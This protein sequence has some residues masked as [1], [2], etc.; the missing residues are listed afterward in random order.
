VENPC[1]QGLSDVEAQPLTIGQAAAR[2]GVSARYVRRLL[3][4]PELAAMV[5]H[6]TRQTR[7]GERGTRLVSP[8][9]FLRLQAI[10]THKPDAEPN[11][12]RGP[13]QNAA[14]RGTRNETTE[15]QKAVPFSEPEQLTP[16]GARLVAEMEGRILDLQRQLSAANAALEREQQNH[17]RTQTLRALEAPT[18]AQE[19][20]PAADDTGNG[21]EGAQA[22]AGEAPGAT[23]AR[24]WLGRLFGRR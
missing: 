15:S 7:T 21:P 3:E 13:E 19:T 20:R 10:T 14:E 11:E 8:A 2:L 22:G 24:S 4:R 17:A 23:A 1:S 9:L 12:E 16:L 18:V 5:E 6:G